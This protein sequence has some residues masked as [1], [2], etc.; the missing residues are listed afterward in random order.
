MKDQFFFFSS[1]SSSSSL[2]LNWS[3]LYNKLMHSKAFSFFLN[4]YYISVFSLIE[5]II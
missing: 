4:I 1:S 3:R 2:L 5:A